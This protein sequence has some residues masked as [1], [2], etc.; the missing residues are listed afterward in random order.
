MVQT[1]TLTKNADWYESTA[2][3]VS[4]DFQ[5]Q[6]NFTE[7]K[8]N[9]IRIL[10]SVDGTNFAIAYRRK[11]D[12]KNIC[13]PVYPVVSGTYVK[14]QSLYNTTTCKVLDDSEE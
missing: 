3:Q 1:I 10:T 6:M 8:G 2:F 11:T 5:L 9:E 4:S 13:E 7:A 14:L 12:E